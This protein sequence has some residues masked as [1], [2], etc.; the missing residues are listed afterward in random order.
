M[1]KFK[2]IA[3]SFIFVCQLSAQ[4]A[5]GWRS[6][7]RHAKSLKQ[8]IHAAPQTI[9]PASDL[10]SKMP[11]V[12]DQ[13]QKGSCSANAGAAD[14]EA[15]WKQAHGSFLKVS[16]QGLYTCELIHDGNWPSDEGSY[17]T[18][19]IWVLKNQG[20]GTEKCFPYSKPVSA[21]LPKCYLPDAAKHKLIDAYDVD[22]T[23]G[24]SIRAALT[25]GLPVVFGGYVYAD[26]QR[27]QPPYILPSP[28]GR[29]IGGHEMTVVGHD[30]AKQIYTV[31]NSWGASWGDHGHLYIKY[32]DMH[33]PRIYEDFA[34]MKLTN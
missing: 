21:P 16:R 23:D 24:T 30:D 13:G 1:S 26:I 29:P 22:N 17:T 18:S 4:P 32:E 3:L 31:R 11:P 28:K 9:A 25:A 5:L 15:L 19:I 20:V 7:P 27:L 8:F 6:N 14:F 2:A 12:Y 34:A 10:R 33:N